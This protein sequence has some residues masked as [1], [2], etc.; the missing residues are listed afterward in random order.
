VEHPGSPGG[1]GIFNLMASDAARV[2]PVVS[3]SWELDMGKAAYERG[4]KVIRERI[5]REQA[6]KP[7]RHPA[8]ISLYHA[9]RI[10]SNLKRKI[11]SLELRLERCERYLR[12]ARAERDALNDDVEALDEKITFYKGWCRSLNANAERLKRSWEKASRLLRLL[13]RDLVV[14]ARSTG[15]HRI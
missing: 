2:H 12:L 13:P 1:C 4:S 6:E 10:N 9:E 7:Q 8:E 3:L 15:E 5:A 11:E 14:E